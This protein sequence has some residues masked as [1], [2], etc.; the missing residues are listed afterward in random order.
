MQKLVPVLKS[1]DMVRS[2]EFYQEIFG[3]K[4][5]WQY[6]QDQSNANPSYASLS[7][8]DQEIHISSFAGDGS[9]GSTIYFYMDDID[10]LHEQLQATAPSSLEMKPTLQ[11]WNMYELYVRDPDN[12][13]LRFGVDKTGK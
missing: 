13:N 10:A 1:F 6:Q 8:F 4:V 3:A 7:L 12:N 2:L 5:N 9:F 11:P